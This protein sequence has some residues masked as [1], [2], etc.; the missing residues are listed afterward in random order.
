M[1]HFY[2]VLCIASTW[3]DQILRC[4]QK[5]TEREGNKCNFCISDTYFPKHHK[6][7]ITTTGEA[8]VQRTSVLL[9]EPWSQ[10]G[11]WS[12]MRP[13]FLSRWKKRC[14]QDYHVIFLPDFFFIHQ[15]KITGD[16]LVFWFLQCGRRLGNCGINPRRPS[17]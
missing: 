5:A 15:S 14:S 17:D 7:N 2:S 12:H 1:A 8:I 13:L 11:R 16:C 10:G 3:K 6:N 9:E 4:L